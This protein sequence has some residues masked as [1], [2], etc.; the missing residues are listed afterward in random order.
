MN[1]LCNKCGL[2]CKLI[3]TVDN[4]IIRDGAQQIEDFFFPID[5]ADALNINENYVHYVQ[6]QFPNAVFYTC[7]YLSNDNLCTHP[8]KPEQCK[9]FPQS[10]FALI[11][12]D[13]GYSGEIFIKQEALKQKIR[14][15]KEEIIHYE[16]LIASN[17]KEKNSYL[18]IINSHNNFIKRYEKFGSENW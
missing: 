17:P 4:I 9:N 14:K 18:K 11:N 15:L 13:C 1:N 6:N 2:C 10:P 5:I 16:A 7:R 3:P 8:D 12:V